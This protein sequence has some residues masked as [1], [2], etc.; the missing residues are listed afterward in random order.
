MRVLVIGASGFVGNETYTAF[1]ENHEVFGTYCKTT[2]SGMIKLD[3]TNKEEVERVLNTILPDAVIQPAAQ[4]WVDF[5]EQQP[6]ES[7]K[8][9][10][11]GAQ[12]IIDWCARH[13]KYYLFVSTDYVFD[14]QNGPY[15][16]DVSVHPLN[17]YG[18]HKLQVEEA[19]LQK[20]PSLGCVARTTTV[21]GWESAGKNFVAKFMFVSELK[22]LGK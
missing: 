16:E 21:Y 4:P 10:F 14:G 17:V 6:Q 5:C 8:I 19:V 18:L 20:L 9:N 13:Q 22:N 3:I 1:H 11:L 7:E 2:L 12:H 15:T